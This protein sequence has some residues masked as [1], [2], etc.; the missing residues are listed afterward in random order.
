MKPKYAT[1]ILDNY[2]EKELTY[3]I[4]EKLI[5]NLQV[6]MRVLVPVKGFL[7]KGYVFEISNKSDILKTFFIHEII[8]DSVIPLKLFDLALWMSKYYC[9][10]LSKVLKCI[11]P[12]SIRTDVHPK[13]QVFLSLN[14][15]KKQIA[16][17]CSS[18]SITHQQITIL[19]ILLKEKKGMFL[20]DLLKD[21]NISK[22]PVDT[23]IKKKLLKST[24]VVADH[25]SIL[26]ENDYFETKPKT[27]ND[28]QKKCLSAIEKSIEKKIFQTHLI[29]GITGSGKTEIYL[30]AIKKT[31]E[32]NKN[33]IML[34]PEIALTSQTIEIFRARFKNKIAILHHRRSLGERYDAW[35]NIKE[36]KAN[37]VIGARSAVFSPVNN[38]G[39]IIVDEEHDSSYKQ[40]DESPTYNA[41][42]V[43]VMRGKLES[44]T[45]VLGSATPAIESYYNA[46]LKKYLL[47]TLTKR[48]NNAQLPQV[49]IIDMKRN[50]TSYIFSDE[51]LKAIDERYK[52]G[53][54]TILFL[55]RRGYSPYIQCKKCD[56]IFK[57]PHC[58]ISLSFHKSK[59]FL[60]CHICGF[61]K[62]PNLLCP[63]CNKEEHIKH[64]GFGTEQVQKTLYAIL[65]HIRTLRIDRDTTMQKNSHDLLLKQFKAGKADVLIGTQ[66]I[67]KGLHF[68]TVTLVGVLNTDSA[69]NIPDYRSSEN[70]FQLL[71]QVAGRAGREELYGEVIIQTYIPDN[72]TVQLAKKQDYLSFYKEELENRKLFQYPP[73]NCIAKVLFIGEKEIITF[74]T[75]KL[76]KQNLVKELPSSYQIYPIIKPA[77]SKVK[78]KY[79]F[80]FLIFGKNIS[81]LSEKL[82]KIMQ[83]IKK[84]TIKII[85]DINPLSIS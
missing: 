26:L 1:V 45:V 28:E 75:A 63:T 21:T 66:M 62:P 71:T 36:N 80:Q 68:P 85:F 73:F 38:L 18:L 31:L 47:H 51:L 84:S 59:N 32:Q 55:N 40:V 19:Q 74:E 50:K 65:P 42:D 41:R 33:V 27:L 46:T 7:R 53:E 83:A 48:A 61:S 57:C 56:H 77:R 13:K 5:N 4:P 3:K 69:L 20:K 15:P 35:K 81:F 24:N 9:T 67:V 82:A 58:D 39:L 76:F 12:P 37:I 78:D 49:S 29:Y 14:K 2:I 54:Q 17:L 23:L 52:K 10:Y 11:I 44:C 60:L 72:K 64:S 6:G 70:V 16:D 25:D 8:S 30:Q 43:A 34:V 22:S 79:Y